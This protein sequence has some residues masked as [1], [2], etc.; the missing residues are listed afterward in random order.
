MRREFFAVDA[1]GVAGVCAAA[2]ARDDV[3]A[4]GEE[5]D[6]LALAF[7][8]PLKAEHATVAGE[9]VVGH[10]A[11][12]TVETARKGVKERAFEEFPDRTNFRSSLDRELADSR[13]I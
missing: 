4:I 13:E 11:R 6:D 8:A 5:V 3:G 1:H 2:I 12:A 10:V 9:C 7:I